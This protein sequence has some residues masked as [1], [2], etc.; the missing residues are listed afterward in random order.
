[1]FHPYDTGGRAQVS[2]MNWTSLIIQFATLLVSCILTVGTCLA[3]LAALVS[4]LLTLKTVEEIRRQSHASL[5]S[6]LLSEYAS[7]EM[8]AAMTGLR[9]WQHDHPRD[10]AAKYGETVNKKEEQGNRL[11]RWRRR[12]THYFTKVMVLCNA[13]L[14]ETCLVYKGLGPG[15]AEF[16]LEVL[17]PIEIIHARE[18][19]KRQYGSDT[20]D[21]FRC[22][23]LACKVC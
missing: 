13:D 4:A 11:N 17:E 16:V 19:T 5:M 8:H 9:D 3:A 6:Q 2:V 18:V 14:I 23:Y 7:P 1:M 20:F 12:A 22:Q 21:F 15:P 10:F